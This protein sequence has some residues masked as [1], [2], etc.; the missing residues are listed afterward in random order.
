LGSA[1]LFH[2]P[3][4]LTYLVFGIGEAFYD[5]KSQKAISLSAALLSMISHYLFGLGAELVW[6]FRRNMFLVVLVTV[7]LHAAW[8]RLILALGEKRRE[9]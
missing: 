2:A 4:G 7:I 8:N 1:S 9:S 3:F 5:L 6:D